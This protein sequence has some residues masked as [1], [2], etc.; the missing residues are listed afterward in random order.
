V[1]TLVLFLDIHARRA[2]AWMNDP[3]AP[4]GTQVV[5]GLMW[6]V[7]AIGLLFTVPTAMVGGIFGLLS[8]SD[9]L[10][11]PT[12]LTVILVVVVAALLLVALRAKALLIFGMLEAAAGLALA[13]QAA[14]AQLTGF[15]QANFA[16]LVGAAAVV[17]NGLHTCAAGWVNL[18][19]SARGAVYNSGRTTRFPRK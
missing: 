16:I 4:L 13:W 17:G 3:H 5:R 18:V 15:P 19:H 6:T 10:D 1:S 2:L 12:K 7:V 8:R 11:V 14:D 9:Q